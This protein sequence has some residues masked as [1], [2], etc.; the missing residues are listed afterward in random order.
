[1]TLL[2]RQALVAKLCALLFGGI[3]V[4]CADD[5]ILEEQIDLKE[6]LATHAAAVDCGCTYTVPSKTYLVDGIALGIKPGAVICL[7]AANTY[8]NIV[9]RNLKG[10]ST[11][12]ITIKNCGGTATLTATGKGFGIK[13][14]LSQYIRITGGTGS[15]Y[16]I[17]VLGG[18][19]GMSLEKLTT[20]VEVDHVE[21]ASTGFAGIMAKT[22]PTCDNSTIRGN[23]VMR[24]VFLHD[25]YIH[26]TGGEGFYVGHTFYL[27]GV[28]TS[29]GTRLPH[30]LENVK[31]YNNVV[32]NSGWEAIQVGSVPGGV[33]VYGNKI[34]NYGVKN[35]AWQKNGVQFGE[36][37]PG[38]FYNNLIKG[39]KGIGLFILSNGQNTVYN[40]IIVNTGEDGIFCDDR[41][42]TGP[43]F[44]FINNTIINPGTNGMRIY[45]DLVTMNNVYNNIIVNPGKYT[46]YTYPRSG[47]DAYVYLLSKT[48]RVTMSNNHFTR[49]VA[50]LKFANASAY[51]YALTSLSPV[52]NK[53]FNISIYN[54][55]L[56]YAQQPR[57][58]S[59]AYDIGA[60]EY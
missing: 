5:R 14:E 9:F 44:K 43:G 38:R 15:T 50:T 3:F 56:D 8:Y 12:P 36:G 45:S 11:S 34:E 27:Q 57:L 26:D 24:N 35:V 22:E 28:S 46:S 31:I 30:I 55:P 20:Y 13:T 17:K 2:K 60:Y 54:I 32:K 59:T 37:A 52:I 33:D 23:F 42:A 40:N 4:G 21:V 47:N 19:Q 29:C 48:M 1:M 39:G 41:T 51:N 18:Q 10:T 49:D 25:N 16:G 53:G 6:D 58:K 7:N